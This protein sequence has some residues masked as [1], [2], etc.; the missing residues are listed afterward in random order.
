MQNGIEYKW[1]SYLLAVLYALTFVMW[2]LT[3]Q[4][5]IMARVRGCMHIRTAL[6]GAI[7]R[8]V[9]SGYVAFKLYELL[10]QGFCIFSN[11]KWNV[12][13]LFSKFY[14]N[15]NTFPQE[16]N[17]VTLSP[18]PLTV[19][20]F[21]IFQ[22]LKLSSKARKDKTVGEIV[23]LVTVDI[24]KVRIVK[25]MIQHPWQ[26]CK[27]RSICLTFMNCDGLQLK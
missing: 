5:S 24:Q 27:Q 19:S 18:N 8:K 23:N 16:G 7:Y 14:I 20:R 21:P 22:S 26:I 17:M 13:D 3:I 25:F 12:V 2:S 11:R 10:F 4:F 1:R 6:T 15:M 9:W